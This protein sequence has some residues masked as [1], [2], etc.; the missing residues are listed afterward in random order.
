MEK[1]DF[2][3]VMFV[4]CTLLFTDQGVLLPDW[5]STT[6]TSPVLFDANFRTC[7]DADIMFNSVENFRVDMV[8]AETLQGGIIVVYFNETVQC[9]Q[10]QVSY[11][12]SKLYTIWN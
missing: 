3:R 4:L 8:I 9:E 7:I 11:T 6:I 2:K 1:S 5:N 12:V 10:K